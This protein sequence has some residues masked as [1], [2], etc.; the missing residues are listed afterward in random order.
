ME[1]TGHLI[2]VPFYQLYGGLDLTGLQYRGKVMVKVTLVQA[3]RLCTGRTAYR[4][5]RGIALPFHDHGTRR[6][7]RHAPAALCPR[8]RPDPHCTG[9]WVGTRTGQN[10]CRKSRPPPG[11][12]LQTVQAVASRY[13]D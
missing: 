4:G 11:F 6:G 5:S 9:G 13:I 7:Q 2:L 8:E 3:L 10:S 1:Q 12:D